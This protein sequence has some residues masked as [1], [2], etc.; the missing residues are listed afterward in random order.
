MRYRTWPTPCSPQKT[1]ASSSTSVDRKI[2][3]RLAA[4][5]GLRG[6]QIANL[7]SLAGEQRVFVRGGRRPIGHSD[8]AS[9]PPSRAV[10]AGSAW[11]A[12]GSP[13]VPGACPAGP[14]TIR[15][16]S[17]SRACERR[18]STASRSTAHQHPRTTR[19]SSRQSTERTPRDSRE[20]RR[21]ARRDEMRQRPTLVL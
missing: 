13:A 12:G 18:A 2:E 7:R 17:T 15:G 8:V 1:A 9:K 14:L 4:G 20:R 5:A 21:E 10:A 19:D 6:R 3:K 16:V 11:W